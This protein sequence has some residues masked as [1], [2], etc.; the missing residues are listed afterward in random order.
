MSKQVLATRP[1]TTRTLY[2][3]TQTYVSVGVEVQENA[4]VWLKT[5]SAG[6]QEVIYKDDLAVKDLDALASYCARLKESYPDRFRWVDRR[7]GVV[8]VETTP[9]TEEAATISTVEVETMEEDHV[10]CSAL[11]KAGKHEG[12][13]RCSRKVENPGD[14]C[15]QHQQREVVGAPPAEMSTLMATL[16]KRAAVM[17]LS[18]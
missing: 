16:G 3:H 11:V 12:H 13:K 8:T 14:M 10:Y 4:S 15:H 2:T 18:K 5:R 9:A 7:Q 1:L 6:I 17:S